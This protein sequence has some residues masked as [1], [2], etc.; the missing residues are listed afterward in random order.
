MYRKDAYSVICHF[1]NLLAEKAP[2][3]CS[4]YGYMLR[5]GQGGYHTLSVSDLLLQ[6]GD[7]F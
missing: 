4:T 1:K 6:I 2:R 7:R 5:H 3:L